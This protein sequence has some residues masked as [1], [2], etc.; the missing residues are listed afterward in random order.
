MFIEKKVFDPKL[1]GEAVYIKGEKIDGVKLD[2]LF[3]VRECDGDCIKL[4]DNRGLKYSLHIKNFEKGTLQ[5]SMLHKP[6]I[7]AQNKIQRMRGYN[8]NQ[9]DKS[10][11]IAEN[12]QLMTIL[13]ENIEPL[14]LR[15]IIQKMHLHGFD[16]WNNKNASAFMRSAIRNGYPVIKVEHGKYSYDWNGENE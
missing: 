6:H 13:R 16:N 10:Q 1:Q 4:I 7:E 3:F 9:R 14:A 5:M 11:L 8:S 12:E 2:K 15:K